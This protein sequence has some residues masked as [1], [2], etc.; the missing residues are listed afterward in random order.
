MTVADLLTVL[1][2][3]NP[4]YYIDVSDNNGET[5]SISSA[6][7]YDTPYAG[8]WGIATVQVTCD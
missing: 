4:D 8:G 2:T 3:L 6:R 1:Q 7:Q 5:Y